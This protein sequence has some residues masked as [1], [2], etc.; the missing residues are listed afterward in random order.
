[1]TTARVAAKNAKI[2]DQVIEMLSTARRNS[3]KVKPAE[4]RDFL[5]FI[6]AVNVES[7]NTG[8][9]LAKIVSKSDWQRVPLV[10]K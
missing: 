3:M 1:M 4:T 5:T 10:K 7:R 9:A 6:K 2:E 8:A